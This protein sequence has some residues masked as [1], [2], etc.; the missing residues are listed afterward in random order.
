MLGSVNLVVR[1]DDYY[2]KN[3]DRPPP[4]LFDISRRDMSSRGSHGWRSKSADRFSAR[5][6]IARGIFALA[7]TMV[8]YFG[9]YWDWI[10]R[11]EM[12]LT[13]TSDIILYKSTLVGS[14]DE[15]KH[16]TFWALHM[17][18]HEYDELKNKSFCSAFVLG[19][20]YYSYH[21]LFYKKVH[22]I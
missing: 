21:R 2:E 9:P 10:S 3:G 5:T 18:R 4:T 17:N 12:R 1:R 11:V 8:N 7:F 13:L 19:V 6:I 16:E 22:F 20:L 15:T 14:H